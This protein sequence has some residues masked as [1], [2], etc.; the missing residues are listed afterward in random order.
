MYLPTRRALHSIDPELSDVVHQ[1]LKNDGEVKI[2]LDDDG[3]FV[4]V[5][6]D[7]EM[8]RIPSESF[9]YPLNRMSLSDEAQSLADEY[10]DQR[11]RDRIQRRMKELRTDGHSAAEGVDSA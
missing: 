8:S 11:Q 4:V 6:D 5:V 2:E 7:I 3:W 10:L 1:A 9:D